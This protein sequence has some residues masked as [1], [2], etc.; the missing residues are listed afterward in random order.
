[1]AAAVKPSAEWAA[2]LAEGRRLVELCKGLVA[3]MAGS[4]GGEQRAA[5]DFLAWVQVR[6]ALLKSHVGG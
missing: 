2:R 3:G 4:G 6:P 1:M 5:G